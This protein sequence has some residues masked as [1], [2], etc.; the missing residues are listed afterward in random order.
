[1]TRWEGQKFC[2]KAPLCKTGGE[3][4]E[5]YYFWQC[6][7]SATFHRFLPRISLHM[8]STI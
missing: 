4:M 3:F 5:N 7:I 8:F 2:R 6:V 1:V